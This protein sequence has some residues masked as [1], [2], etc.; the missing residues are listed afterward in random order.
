[1]I[2]SDFS[3]EYMVISRRAYHVHETIGH[4][5]GVWMFL[6]LFESPHHKF[7]WHLAH[8]DVNLHHVHEAFRETAGQYHGPVQPAQLVQPCAHTLF[9]QAGWMRAN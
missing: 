6:I 8:L 2:E 4:R 5:G 3:A 7:I 9:T 1:M